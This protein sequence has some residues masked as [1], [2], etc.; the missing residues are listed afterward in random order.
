MVNAVSTSYKDN[1]CSGSV[2]I[3]APVPHCYQVELYHAIRKVIMIHFFLFICKWLP[4]KLW[5]LSPE[6]NAPSQTKKF[7]PDSCDIIIGAWEN[8]S[9][10]KRYAI[11]LVAHARDSPS[12]RPG[13]V[14]EHFARAESSYSKIKGVT[15]VWVINFCTRPCDKDAYVW[16]S[17]ESR[18][19]VM[20]IYH[21]L[22]WKKATVVVDSNKEEPTVV[23]F[24]P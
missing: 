13:T 10:T 11:E 15:E 4:S 9:V 19:R 17:K 24:P 22:N 18:L 7:K 14:E 3:G 20:H 6:A 16:P 23:N 1:E 8:Q 5:I 12:D 2:K 21:S